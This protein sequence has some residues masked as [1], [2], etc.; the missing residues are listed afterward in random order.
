MSNVPL[1]PGANCSSRMLLGP[2]NLVYAYGLR[3]VVERL[4]EIGQTNLFGSARRSSRKGHHRA[5][6]RVR[7]GSGRLIVW[8]QCRRGRFVWYNDTFNV[9]L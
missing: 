9:Q 2:G 6:K 7:G 1:E 4:S 5:M 3:I 8:G